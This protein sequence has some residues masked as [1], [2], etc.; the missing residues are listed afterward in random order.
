VIEENGFF[1]PEQH[2]TRKS[3]AFPGVLIADLMK[4]NAHFSVRGQR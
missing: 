2:F 4:M 1:G 3:H